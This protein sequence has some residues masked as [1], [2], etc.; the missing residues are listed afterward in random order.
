MSKV[1]KNTVASMTPMLCKLVDVERRTN[2]NIRPTTIRNMKRGGATDREIITVTGHRDTR[3]L[4]SYDP[5]VGNEKAYAM[6]KSIG[7][8]GLVKKSGLMP[9]PR[10]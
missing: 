8:A 7:D 4:P 9:P 6:A 5:N 3:N 2:N 1:G 10:P